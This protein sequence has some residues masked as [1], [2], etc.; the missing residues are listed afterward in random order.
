MA[1]KEWRRRPSPPPGFARTL[2]LLPFQAH[3]LYNRGI[4]SE[5]ELGA[6]LTTDSSLSNDPFLLPDM[7][8]A[9]SRLQRAL[10]AGEVVAIFGD[11]DADGVTSSALLVEALTGLGARPIAYIP[12]RVTEGHGLNVPALRSL[13]RQGVGIVVTADCG[14]SDAAEV[15]AAADLGIDVV[16]TDHH[17]PPAESRIL[18]HQR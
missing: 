2:G 14:V 11:F 3:L 17:S 16:I 12:H 13:H 15:A 5:A 10:T 1:R 6:F 9:V 8:S 4:T 7:G 18:F